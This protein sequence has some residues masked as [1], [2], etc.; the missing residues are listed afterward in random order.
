MCHVPS[1]TDLICYIFTSGTT[2]LPKACPIKHSRYMDKSVN[3]HVLPVF[4]YRFYAM[5]NG[6]KGIA[7][8]KPNDVI[9]NALPLYHTSGGVLAPGQ[10]LISGAT[11]VIRKTFS[12]SHFWTDCIEHKCTVSE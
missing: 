4:L 5:Q 8:I 12:A 6:L 9:Y 10:M 1:A 7:Q 11:L 3:T 2:G